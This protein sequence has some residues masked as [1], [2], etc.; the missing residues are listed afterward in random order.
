MAGNSSRKVGKKHQNVEFHQF[1]TTT[2]SHGNFSE[3]KE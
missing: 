1:V 2:D 3:K